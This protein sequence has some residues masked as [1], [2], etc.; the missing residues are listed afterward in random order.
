MLTI[1]AKGNKNLKKGCEAK[2]K[3]ISFF[4]DYTQYKVEFFSSDIIFVVSEMHS[5][6]TPVRTVGDSVVISWD[7]ASFVGFV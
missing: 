3:E 5:H 6:G 4:G 1:K 7:P 2:I